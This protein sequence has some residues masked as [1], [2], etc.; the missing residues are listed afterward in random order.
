MNWPL[1]KAEPELFARVFAEADTRRALARRQ[2]VTVETRQ[3]AVLFESAQLRD[4]YHHAADFGVNGN[5]NPDNWLRFQQALAEHLDD[6]GTYRHGNYRGRENEPV[7]YNPET[8]RIA[9][10]KRN[11]EFVTAFRF[12]RDSK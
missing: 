6:K 11:G 1:R 4:K 10:L 5:S 9:V 8:L 3:G 2:S 12:D 7:Y